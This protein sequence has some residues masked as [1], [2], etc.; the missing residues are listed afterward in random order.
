MYDFMYFIQYFIL[1]IKG[2]T[3][4]PQAGHN[5]QTIRKWT[6]VPILINGV[7][8]WRTNQDDQNLYTCIVVIKFFN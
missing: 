3:G 8:E 4:E 7:L 6:F 2:L 1:P 5:K